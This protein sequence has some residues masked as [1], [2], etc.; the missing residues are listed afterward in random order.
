MH[1]TNFIEYTLDHY[2]STGLLSLL[3]VSHLNIQW[4]IN[5]SYYLEIEFLLSFTEAGWGPGADNRWNI[6]ICSL[7][8]QNVRIASRPSKIKI[9]SQIRFPKIQIKLPNNRI[10]FDCRTPFD[11]MR[12]WE[13]ISSNLP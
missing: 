12:Q 1:F 11:V 7:W 8:I 2:R 4:K 6:K 13:K 5:D 3:S 9:N 10:P